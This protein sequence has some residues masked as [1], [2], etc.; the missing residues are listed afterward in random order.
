MTIPEKAEQAPPS[1]SPRAARKLAQ[2]IEGARVVIVAK[3]FD[4]ASV[5]DIARQAGIS[6]ATMYRYFPDKTALFEAVMTHD[7]ARQAGAAQ[8]VPDAGRPIA[9]VLTDFAVMH[10]T[11]VLSAYAIGAFRTAVAESARF[12]EIASDFYT[13]RIE[14]TQHAVQTIL[15]GAEARGELVFDDIDRAT[16]QFLALCTTNPFFTQLFGVRAPFA[17]EEIAEHAEGAVAAF[18]KILCPRLGRAAEAGGGAW[19]EGGLIVRP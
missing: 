11:F 12:P 17:P 6:K 18:L 16:K 4:G 19:K 8:R 3:G 5:D 14:R 13:H 9:E 7:C 10:L 15:E 2:V 1:L